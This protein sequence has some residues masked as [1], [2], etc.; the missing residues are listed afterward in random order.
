[1]TQFMTTTFIVDLL[2]ALPVNIN[3]ILVKLCTLKMEVTYLNLI[4]FSPFYKWSL[5]FSLSTSTFVDS[6]DQIL[7]RFKCED[8]NN[9]VDWY[10]NAYKKE[11]L[12]KRFHYANN[13]RIEEVVLNVADEWLI[14]R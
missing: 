9:T 7:E 11:D 14:Q 6:P 13:D 8:Y 1:M 10:L 4:N 3:T 5:I 2:D 12:P